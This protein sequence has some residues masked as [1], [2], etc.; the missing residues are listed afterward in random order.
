MTT[1]FRLD[2]A[3][4][5]SYAKKKPPFGFNGLG[6]LVYL[7][8]YSRKKADG[9][10]ERWF[11]TVERVVNGTYTMQKKHIESHSLGWVE[12]VA[13]ESAQEMYVRIFQMLFL[14]PG[15][16]LWAM[17][18]PITEERGLYAALNNCAFISTANLSKELS[19]PFCF[20]MDASCLGIGTGFDTKGAGSIVIQEPSE[21]GS[22]T[23]VIADSREGWVESLRRLIDSYFVSESVVQYFDYSL[24][25]PSGTEIRGFGGVASGPEP[26]RALLEDIRRILHLEIGKG[27]SITSI[28]DIMNLVGRCVVA[29]N[30]RRTA[31]IAFGDYRSE[32]FINLKNYELNPERAAYGWASNN[33]IFADIGMDYN[34]IVPQIIANGEPGL[35]WLD[36][37]R[38]YSRMN[39]TSD[40]KDHRVAGGNPC[41][42]NDTRV[43]TDKGLVQIKDLIGKQFN[44]VV[45]GVSY[46]STTK[47]FWLTAEGQPVF[48]IQLDNGSF[49]RCTDN[50]QILLADGSWCEAGKLRLGSDVQLS[51]NT[52]FRNNSTIGTFEEGYVMGQLIGD[53][54]FYTNQQ[55]TSSAV[56]TIWLDPKYENKLDYKPLQI[57]ET[58]IKTLATRSDFLGFN[59]AHKSPGGFNEY[60]LK[61]RALSDLADK[62][63]VYPNSK[64]LYEK[65]SHEFTRGIISGFFDADG[66][67]VGTQAK[68]ISVRL[69]QINLERLEAVQRLLFSLGI[70]S[71][72][73]KYRQKAG[74]RSRP[75]G[76]G[77]SK[78][79]MCQAGHELII[80]NRSIVLFRDI[81]GFQDNDK[82][83]K[84]DNLIA[85][86]KRAPNHS[87]Y[88]SK[89]TAIIADGREDV[90]DATIP[91]ISRFSAN[92]IIVHNCLEQSLESSELCVL[93]ESFPAKH[94]SLTD[95]K[96]TLKFAYLYAKTVTLGKTHWPETNRISL[97][98]R[99]IG[100]SMSGIAQ[101]ITKHGIET[102]REWCEEGYEIIDHYDQIYSDWLC[103][104][105]SIKTTSIKPSGSVSLL[106]GAT[107]GMHYPES[108]FY[109]RRVRLADKSDLI[110][111]LVDAG[112]HIEKDTYSPNTSVV[113]FPID[114]GAGIRIQ[115]EVSMWEQLSL[116]S[117]LQKHWG[118][119]QISST[120]TFD[121][122][123]EGP[124]IA[125]ALNYFQYQLKGISFLPRLKAGA[126]RQMP[127]ESCTEEQYN[128]MVSKLRP[129]NLNDQDDAVVERFCDGESCMMALPNKA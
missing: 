98:N 51:E 90:Y 38:A 44:A 25:R 118:N 81:V 7:R 119:N 97:R 56:I 68:G 65:G 5:A 83:A 108:R 54:T 10:K 35:A 31:E 36:N 18:S 55:G 16:G 96:R 47:G 53:G 33:S 32:E 20:L 103:I 48:R 121:P 40:Y 120:I 66:C 80:A 14:P 127:Y 19:K 22:Q 95:Y 84:L 24:I 43:L 86:Y 41:L 94:K 92:G 59:F 111:G 30:V 17:G 13:Q 8:T 58:F 71:K 114:A 39:G 107:A 128:D 3:F 129:L 124:Q 23:Y 113:T 115:S 74:M 105:R 11:E 63:E 116:A 29:G 26:L 75:N 49:V 102:L 100:C 125:S 88:V 45:N 123:T 77:G 62:F 69:C 21:L 117:F 67:V 15:R 73:F 9:S 64:S 37:M 4:V 78:D 109:M 6:E 28:V 79:Y 104:P 42:T 93:V 99:R 87:K 110:P 57:V 70:A 101:F 85:Q 91:G 112:Y 122:E 106:A 34:Q 46:P 27:I 12:S 50:H 61:C 76:K 52:D 1:P 126:Y 89:V 72:I 2:P 82:K 60:R